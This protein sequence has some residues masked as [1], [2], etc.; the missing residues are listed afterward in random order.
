MILGDGFVASY[1]NRKVDWGFPSGPNSVGEMVFRRTYSRDGER[2]HECVA[3]VVEGT[4]DILQSHCKKYTLPFDLGRARDTAQ[5]MF[6]RIWSFRFTPPGRGLWIMGTPFV[7]ERGAAALNNCAFVST[8]NLATDVSKPFRFLMDMSMLGVGV[9]FDTRGAG[10]LTWMSPKGAGYAHVIEDSREGWVESTGAILRWAFGFGPKPILVYDFIRPAGLPIRGF[11]G[12]SSGPDPLRRLHQQIEEIAKRNRGRRLTSRDIVDLFNLIGVCVVAGN[13]RR[14]AEIALGDQNDTEFLDLKNYKKNPERGDWGWTSNNSVVV[15][16][17]TTDYEEIAERIRLNGEPGVFWLDTARR[18]SRLISPSDNRDHRVIGTNPCAEQSLESYELCCLVETFLNRADNHKDWWRTL[19]FAYL[20]AKAV[21]L[22]PTH[23]EDT[24][25]VM[26]RNRRIGTSVSGVVQY[27]A[28]YGKDKAAK[29]LDAGYDIVRDW[30]RVYSEWLGVRESIKC[31]SVKPSGTVS[32]LAGATPGAHFPIYNYY[33]RRVNFSKDHPDLAPIAAAGYKVEQNVR[34]PNS[35]IVE[36]PVQGPDVPTEDQV[37][38]E[39]K[40]EVA[41]LLQLWWAD[42]Q[43][44]ATFT[45]NPETEGHLIAPLLRRGEK[46]LKAASFLPLTPKG[47][48]PQMPYEAITRDVYL[49]RIKDL[50]PI[51]WPHKDAHTDTERFCDGD[52]CE[53]TR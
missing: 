25:A 2:W 13:V 35:M 48:Y 43:V 24:N 30:D 52:A 11:G 22:C 4:F 47:S 34:D 42:N 32:L 16:P 33:I 5:E 8:A 51:Q 18:F 3:R 1:A 39:Q 6:E 14:T 45:F 28:K 27:L 38:V 15:K 31:T 41:E 23:W 29:I 10:Q 26:L 36:F 21:T 46:T 9:G 7:R 49:E 12:I 17:G 19:K 40:F 20:Y 44:S 53:V 37:P 50:K